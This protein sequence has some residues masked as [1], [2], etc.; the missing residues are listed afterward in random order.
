MGRINLT[1][2]ENF[3]VEEGNE[4]LFFNEA[5]NMLIPLSLMLLI[6]NNFGWRS[7]AVLLFVIFVFLQAGFRFRV[8]LILA[9]A[10][11]AFAVQRRIRL[12]ISYMLAGGT[13][14]VTLSNLLGMVRRYGQGIDYNSLGE[15]SVEHVSSF[16]GEAGIVYTLGYIADHR[17]P[18]F[19]MFEPWTVGF[20]RLIP[21]FI[22]QDKPML[23]YG[24]YLLDITE[25]NSFGAG[26]AVPQHVEMLFQFG[27]FGLP[28]LAFIYFYIIAYLIHRLN[29]LGYEA[30][31]AGCSLVP[32]FFGFYMQSRGYFFQILS[33]GLFVF[34]PMF[35]VHVFEKQLGS[36]QRLCL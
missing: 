7:L 16:S 5:F 19:V 8:I 4:F 10:V 14:A 13:V 28:L 22:W 12:R 15:A 30:R 32:V 26:V 34:G 2:N 1:A 17:L 20:A 6:R 27:W 23:S 18:D 29:L 3:Q 25:T 9:G 33:D 35:L 31:V 11:T 24:R 36:L 21:S